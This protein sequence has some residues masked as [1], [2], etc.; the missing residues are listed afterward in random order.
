MEMRKLYNGYQIPD[1]AFGTGV[2]MRYTRNPILYLKK[3][4]KEVLSSV[5]HHKLNRN[6]KGDFFCKK[7]L[8][9]AYNA[10]YRL[11][12]T[13]RIYGY[14]EKRIGEMHKEDIYVISK[15]SDMDIERKYMPDTVSGNL[16]L[17]LRYLNREYVDV[18]LLHYPHGE[19]LNI[20][21][22]LEKLYIV[23]QAKSIGL[24]NCGINELETIKKNNLTKPMVIQLELHPLNSK[25][26]LR[27]YCKK[28]EIQIMAHTPTGRMETKIQNS[29]VLNKIAVRYNKTIPQVILRWHYQN[30]IIP[31]LSTFDFCH[32]H[33]NLKIYDFE[34]SQN[35]MEAIDS[36]D[37]GFVL[38]DRNCIDDPNYVYNL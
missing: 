22:Q 5:K 1:V 33:E 28:N 21:R 2:I 17:S 36:I 13:A 8:S 23:G 30:G 27:D 4:I 37:E 29:S 11:Y 34:L 24:C 26:E 14:S 10:G 7:I 25:K 20:Y 19:W 6:L 12:D 32:M 18:Y 9:N 3:S 16:N 15:V 35:E 31:V 38:L